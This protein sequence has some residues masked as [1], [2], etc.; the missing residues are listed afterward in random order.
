MPN[1]MGL[2]EKIIEIH[3]LNPDNITALIKA[4]RSFMEITY[5]DY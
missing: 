1:S 3:L 5:R 2:N 4:I